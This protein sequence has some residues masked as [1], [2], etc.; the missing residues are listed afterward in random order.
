[1]NLIILLF[2]VFLMEIQS[3]KF[4][5]LLV[6][7]SALNIFIIHTVRVRYLILTVQILTSNKIIW[8]AIKEVGVKNSATIWVFNGQLPE[9]YKLFDQIWLPVNIFEQKF[10]I[11]KKIECDRWLVQ[12]NTS[13]QNWRDYFLKM[14]FLPKFSKYNNDL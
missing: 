3:R 8:L 12:S 1:M 5:Y 14:Y 13:L 9:Q 7:K 11:L 6:Q 2:N 4:K 10:C